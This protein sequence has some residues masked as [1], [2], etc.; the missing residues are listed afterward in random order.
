MCA[1]Q[2]R[3]CREKKGRAIYCILVVITLL[4][5]LRL[6]QQKGLRNQLSEHEQKCTR[7]ERQTVS[8]FQKL[9]KQQSLYGQS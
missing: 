2:A 1:V 7:S 9:L 6:V 3:V 5:V 4:Q 8:G